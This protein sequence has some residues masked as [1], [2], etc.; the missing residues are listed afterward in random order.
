MCQ[1]VGL[2]SVWGSPPATSTLQTWPTVKP[3]GLATGR[4]KLSPSLP[5]QAHLPVCQP[6]RSA[7]AHLGW[8]GGAGS[9]SPPAPLLPCPSQSTHGRGRA[10][11][12][13]LW[14]PQSPSAGRTGCR[15]GLGSI[16]R[17][18]NSLRLS[19]GTGLLLRWKGPDLSHDYNGIL[20]SHEKDQSPDTHHIT[21]APLKHRAK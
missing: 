2:K 15:H 12:P 6:G 11:P 4:S 8:Q 5:P 7:E 20:L 3:S 1:G 10:V 21:G 19:S 13:P 17:P 9:Y 18:P 16:V 14:H